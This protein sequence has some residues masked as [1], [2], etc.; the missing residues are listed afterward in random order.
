MNKLHLTHLWLDHGYLLCNEKTHGKLILCTE[1]AFFEGNQ[2][3]LKKGWT[4][5]KSGMRYRTIRKTKQCHIAV[6][7]N[8]LKSITETQFAEAIEE[9]FNLCYSKNLLNLSES[10]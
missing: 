6:P 10:K 3:S 5:S 9:S 1:D 2:D 7:V 8:I 4:E